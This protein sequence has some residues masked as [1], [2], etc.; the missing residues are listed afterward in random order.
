MHGFQE[1]GAESLPVS[2][3]IQPTLD[4]GGIDRLYFSSE[5]STKILMWILIEMLND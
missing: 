5:I 3:L 2:G 4:R 1:E